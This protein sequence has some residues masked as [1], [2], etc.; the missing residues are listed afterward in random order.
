VRRGDPEPFVLRRPEGRPLP[1]VASLPHSGVRV[2]ASIA[3]RF[4]PA[5]RAWLRNTDW[6]L[7]ELHEFLPQVGVTTIAATHSRYVVD[8]NRDPAGPLYGDFHRAV[9]ARTTAPR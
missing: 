4:T 6:H 9:I 2:P 1:I 5:H 3:E 7:P 8:L